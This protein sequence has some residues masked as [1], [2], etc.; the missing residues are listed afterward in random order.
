MLRD[1]L[2]DMLKKE[3]KEVYLF[4]RLVFY[5]VN[6]WYFYEILWCY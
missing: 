3:G 6:C 1:Y 2:E 5:L 4:F